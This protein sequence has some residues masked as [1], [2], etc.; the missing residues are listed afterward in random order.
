MILGKLKKLKK[1]TFTIDGCG[2]NYE[3]YSINVI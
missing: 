3:Q 2:N 1:I